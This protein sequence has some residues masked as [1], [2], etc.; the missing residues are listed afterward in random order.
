MHRQKQDA[1]NPLYRSRLVG[2]EF[3]TYND[4][5]LYAAT[6]P[7]EALRLILSIAATHNYDVMTNDVSRAYS[8]APV[9]EGQYIYVKLPEEDILPGEEQM[10]GRLN[11]SMYGTRRASTN[12][13]SHYTDVLKK[14]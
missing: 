7:L 13:Q 12:W 2:K 9:K 6:P 5:T 10:C 3:N 4:I 11:Y 14:I 1:K 8:Y